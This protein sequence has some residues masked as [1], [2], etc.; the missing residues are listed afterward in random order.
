MDHVHSALVR[1]LQ[2]VPAEVQNS[3]VPKMLQE[4][5]ERIQTASE[6]TNPLTFHFVVVD[7]Q[8][9]ETRQ[10][11]DLRQVLHLLNLAPLQVQILEF[12]QVVQVLE[13]PDGIV[14]QV[15]REQLVQVGQSVDSGDV[16][17]LQVKHPQLRQVGNALDAVDDVVVSCYAGPPRS[18]YSGRESSG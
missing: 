12:V 5:E 17:S 4:P 18:S 2:L 10:F 14:R 13:T 7:G 11:G 9:Q 16:V 6:L 3:E 15:Q 1:S 8:V